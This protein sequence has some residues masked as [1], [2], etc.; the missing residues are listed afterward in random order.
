MGPEVLTS[1]DALIDAR[2]PS[3]FTLDHLPGAVSLP[4]LGDEERA[5][6]G[7]I[8]KQRSPFEARRLGAALV[9]RNIAAHL[10][11]ALADRPKAWRPLVYCWRGGKRS[12]AFAHV[13]R[14]VGWDARPAALK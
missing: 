7:T 9:S 4:V 11:G 3:E 13:L 14:E 2:S 1:Y 10:E 8:Y 6:I 12:G 5:R